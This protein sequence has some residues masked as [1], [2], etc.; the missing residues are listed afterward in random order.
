MEAKQWVAMMAAGVGSCGADLMG[1]AR[2]VAP[3]S[4]GSYTLFP[5]WIYELFDS[6]VPNGRMI[7]E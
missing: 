1:W 5:I 7:N 3:P 2:A 6:K 4:E